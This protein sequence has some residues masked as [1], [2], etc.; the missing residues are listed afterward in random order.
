MLN[1]NLIYIKFVFNI[2]LQP[3]Q[4]IFLPIKIREIIYKIYANMRLLPYR[5]L[6]V[7][8]DNSFSLWQYKSELSTVLSLKL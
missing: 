1:T 6:H 5:F 2:Y 7:K 4:T 3:Y 8:H